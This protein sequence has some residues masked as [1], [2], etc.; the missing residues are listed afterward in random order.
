M[1]YPFT[2]SLK[3]SDCRRSH[4]SPAVLE[5]HKMQ[6]LLN[7]FHR[8]LI[9]GALTSSV[10]FALV[11]SFLLRF[12]F[13]LPPAERI[14]LLCGLSICIPVQ[15]AV[16]Y[17]A[18]IHRGWWGTI[19]FRDIN[20]ILL[21]NC[22]G[23]GL[24]SAAIIAVRGSSYPRS[25]HILDFIVCFA[26]I[27][28]IRVVIRMIRDSRQRRQ[29]NR[30]A[31]NVLIYGAGRAGAGL[32]REI[33]S[34]PKLNYRVLGFLD[35]SPRKQGDMVAGIPV[36]G[37]GRDAIHI[38][39][40]ALRRG[41]TI[42]E[43][44]I[45][46]PSATGRQMHDAVANCGAARVP[47]RTLPGL[48]DLLAKTSL[49]AQIR[50]V[51]VEDLL[52]RE[53]VQL[54]EIGIS[55]TLAGKVVMVTGAAGSIGS[56]IC[57][58]IGALGP[59]K[60]VA[61]DQAESDLYKIDLDLRKRFPDLALSAEIGD[62]RDTARVEEIIREH[63]V[64][65]IFHAAAYKHVPLMESHVMEAVQNN[66]VGT[67]NVADAASRMNVKSF[68]LISSDKAVNP[69][70]VMGATKRAAELIV[71]N[72]AAG[73]PN[74]LTRFV[75]VRFG[76]VLASNGSV[77]PLFQSQ[78]ASGGP[79]TVT[80]PEIRRYFMTVREAVQLVLQASTM[81]KG[82]EIFVLD[83]GEPVR[84]LDLARNMI[85]LSGLEPDEDIEIRFTGLRP[86]EKLFEELLTD[87]EDT[88]PTYHEKIKI[89]RETARPHISIHWW[90]SE[91]RAGIAKRDEGVVIRALLEAIPE[92]KVSSHWSA[93]AGRPKIKVAPVATA[94]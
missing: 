43:I 14:D 69:A 53:A 61:M 39:D 70:N 48:G 64:E 1:K 93:C 65:C 62:I 29:T 30:M 23:F 74:N 91:L 25:V 80:H 90:L 5:G 38:V 58:Q 57:R 21:A 86:G 76:N 9:F 7:R 11:F 82:S 77:V 45:A 79:V 26:S 22:V 88:L 41:R 78:I 89:F 44:L 10:A 55:Q 2:T 49:T 87:S 15:L 51:S 67:W 8:F 34:N 4:R 54:D 73:R 32:A 50:A 36:L 20:R 18:R 33:D 16:F 28:G 71:C 17:L 42:E 31:K 81:G 94:S 35:D 6:Q 24:C 63:H 27:A 47:C 19:G 12:D 40:N 52:A 75:A 72:L 59:H 84:I 66:V 56:E 92:Y 3:F 85:R 13:E 83:M 60:V 46:M 37:P 68:V